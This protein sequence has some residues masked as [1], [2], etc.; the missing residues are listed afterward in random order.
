MNT[1][2][3]AIVDKLRSKGM[4]L[5]GDKPGWYVRITVDVGDGPIGVTVWATDER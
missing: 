1:F 4:V 3:K 2:E 5:A